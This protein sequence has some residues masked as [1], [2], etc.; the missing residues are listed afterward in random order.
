ME[1]DIQHDGDQ[2]YIIHCPDEMGWKARVDLVEHLQQTATDPPARQVI[3]D[4]SGVNMINSAGLGGLFSLRKHV[5]EDGGGQLVLC[6]ASPLIQRLFQTVNM[7]KL[8][9]VVDSLDDARDHLA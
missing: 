8:I 2:R 6:N 7:T 5:V 1:V 3:V 4:F 9:P